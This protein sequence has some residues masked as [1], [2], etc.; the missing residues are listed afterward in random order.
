MHGIDEGVELASIVEGA[1]TLA[2]FV[3]MAPHGL[4][5]ER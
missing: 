5:L 2:R 3:A 1:R 4:Q